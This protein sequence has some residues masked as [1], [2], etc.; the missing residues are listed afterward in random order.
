[1]SCVTSIKRT[2]FRTGALEQIKELTGNDTVTYA[3]MLD[4]GLYC[5]LQ[6]AIALAKLE[7]EIIQAESIL[8]LWK[9]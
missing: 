2:D 3:E 9:K 5:K 1:M 7:P 4:Y 6:A 8:A